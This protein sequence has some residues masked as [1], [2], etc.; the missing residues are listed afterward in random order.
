MPHLGPL[1]L[2]P[3]ICVQASPG[4][5]IILAPEHQRGGRWQQ[6]DCSD[7]RL[8]LSWPSSLS[9]VI[10]RKIDG[11]GN[12]GGIEEL[13]SQATL[14]AMPRIPLESMPLVYESLCRCRTIMKAS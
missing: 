4:N 14:S 5:F 9:G 2:R 6:V 7:T 1:A 13:T 11:A 8:S 12:S 3:P 10:L